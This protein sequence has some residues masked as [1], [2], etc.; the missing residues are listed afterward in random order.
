LSPQIFFAPGRGS[1]YQRAW[2]ALVARS[3]GARHIVQPNTFTLQLPHT[4]AYSMGEAALAN[5]LAVRRWAVG[6]GSFGC[7][8]SHQQA[9]PGPVLS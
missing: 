6:A 4:A 9:W 7:V 8:A 5:F 2:Q 3:M 1:Y